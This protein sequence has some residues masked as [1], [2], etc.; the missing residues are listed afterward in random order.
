MKSSFVLISLMFLSGCASVPKSVDELRSAGKAKSS[1]CSNK[2]FNETV[3][4]IESQLRKCFARGKHEVY[5]GTSDTFIE[6]GGVGS[7]SVTLASVAHVNWN[8]FYQTIVDVSSKNNCPVLVEA[9]GMSDNWSKTTSLVQ[10][11]V[12]G[13]NLDKCD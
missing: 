2:A 1:F 3:E 10:S 11:W 4:I 9:Y 8:R 5:G 7:D 13:N 12:S 6:K